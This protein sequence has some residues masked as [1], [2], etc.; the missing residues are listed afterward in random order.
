MNSANA[1]SGFASTGIWP[2]LG[3]KAIPQSKFVQDNPTQREVEEM[4]EDERSKPD[5][6][7]SVLW[8]QADRQRSAEAK[9][10]LTKAANDLTSMRALETMFDY[11][12]TRQQQHIEY[13]KKRPVTVRAHVDGSARLFTSFETSMQ[14]IREAEAQRKQEEADKIAREEERNRQKGIREQRRKDEAKEKDKRKKDRE[15]KR[16][17][18]E[19]E[20]RLAVARREAAKAE[21][22]RKM[23]EAEATRAQKAL[24]KAGTKRGLTDSD[25]AGESSQSKR[26]RQEG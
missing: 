15:Q 7:I 1:I 12:T 11:T 16:A 6:T 9:A 23:A 19:E 8:A 18:K 21:K 17:A 3:L 13:L 24:E 25:S 14:Q 20:K 10:A 5:D 22:A 2:L 4:V 26:Q